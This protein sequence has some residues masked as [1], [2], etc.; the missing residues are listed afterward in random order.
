M[1]NWQKCRTELTAERPPEQLLLINT[2]VAS[3]T[4]TT[5][6]TTFVDSS[7]EG[8]RKYIFSVEYTP[9]SLATFNPGCV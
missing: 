6:I 9:L 5:T 3:T 8:R 7:M 4:A 1:E 2:Q